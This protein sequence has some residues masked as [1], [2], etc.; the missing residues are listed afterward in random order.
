L[1][2]SLT[3]ITTNNYKNLHLDD[4]LTLGKLNIFIGPNGSGKS[5]LI[6]TLQF[7]Q[8]CVV[9]ANIDSIRGRTN[10][11]D[12]IFRL[13]GPRILDGTITAPANVKLKYRFSA[14]HTDTL[15]QIE[16]LVQSLHRQVIIDQESLG[17]EQGMPEPFYFYIAHNERSGGSGRGV[18]SVFNDP[19]KQFTATH[20]ERIQDIPVN[21]LALAII[22][23]LLETSAFSP[24]KTPVYEPRREMIDTISRW[25]FYNPNNM[26]LFQIRSAEPKLGTSD[27]FISP[28]GENLPLVLY[29]LVQ[30]NFEFEETIDQAIKDIL[31]NTRKLRA[32]TSGRLSLTIE[33]YLKGCKEPFFLNEMSDG[34]VRMLCW[35]IILHSPQLPSLI[36]IDEPEVGIHVAW[37][38]KLADWIKAASRRTQVIIST[39][40]P[41]LLDHFTDQ[42]DGDGNIFVFHGD[43]KSK[44]HNTVRQLTKDAI[45]IQLGEGWQVGDLY[46][47]GDPSVGGWPW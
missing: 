20:F 26:N 31:P 11:E 16:L 1:T 13:G 10:F 29:N 9:E 36:V 14:D 47:V 40:S 34:T 7:L 21:E 27:I 22:P 44:I 4:G 18:V 43:P 46:R 19:Q 32:I 35:A 41:D 6:G 24:E 45:A 2:T 38:P 12:A 25:R 42:L 17:R 28:S 33:W 23:K 15:L 8:Q 30:S 37:M 39:H 3:E 5:N